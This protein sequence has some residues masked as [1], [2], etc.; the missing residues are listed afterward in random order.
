LDESYHG[1][2]LQHLSG[3]VK[4]EIICP[5]KQMLDLATVEDPERCNVNILKSANDR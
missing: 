4:L 5:E 1:A 3:R 2:T